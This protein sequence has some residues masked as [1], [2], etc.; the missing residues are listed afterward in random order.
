MLC[1]SSVDKKQTSCLVSTGPQHLSTDKSLQGWES[2]LR[3]NWLVGF[4]QAATEHRIVQENATD[5]SGGDK[6]E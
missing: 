1:G 4:S 6:E 2:C 3:E 5:I